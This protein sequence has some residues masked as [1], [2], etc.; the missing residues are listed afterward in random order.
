YN[1]I[2][3]EIDAAIQ[4]V[5]DTTAFVRGP[6]VKRFEEE[7]AALYG[8]NH[9]ISVANGTDA[10]Y[11]A[12]KACGIGEGDEVITVTNSW[13][14]SSETI[15][16][17]GA[18]VVFVDYESDYYT[19][20]VTKIEE[21]ITDKTKA[22][23]PVHLYGQ[24]AEMETLRFL[25]DKYE[26]YLIEDCAQAHFAE[27]KGKKA[28][29]FRDCGT[30]SFYPGKNLGAYGDG[31]AIITNNETLAHQ[32]RMIANHGSLEKH[33]HEIEGINSRLDGLQ[34]AILSVKL[35]Y[36]LE[37]NELRLKNAMLYNK[38][39]GDI[40]EVVVPKIRDGCKHIFHLY[41]IRTKK[42]DELMAH[43]K[44]KG[45]GV[46]I[47]YPRALPFLKAYEYL[48]HTE[49]DFP[50][51]F[52]CQDEILSLPMYPELTEEHIRYVVENIR[53]FF[54]NNK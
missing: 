26:L 40:E 53:N 52:S 12:L 47:H 9:C 21:K 54:N 28:G 38:L 41:V 3:G 25:C 11:I 27:Y 31:G 49:R 20:D 17:T 42:R 24:A 14:S 2:K 7:F 13:I 1:N 32:M 18:R 6:F 34:A 37:W 35:Q 43:L 10:I 36:I 16:Q 8:V 19:I 5:I 45:I 23:I 51:A 33:K 50:V 30:F 22:I 44:N 46:A 15:T 4:S 29:T 39:L 48:N